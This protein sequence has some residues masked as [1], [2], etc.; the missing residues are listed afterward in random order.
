MMAEPV[1]LKMKNISKTFPGVKALDDVHIDIKRGEVHALMG[2]N[3]AGKSTLI[4]IISGVQKPDP[5]G[6]IWV[7]GNQVSF[8]NA[9]DSIDLGINAIYQ[10]LS[11]F[12]NL[13]VAENIYLGHSTRLVNWKECHEV[14]KDVLGRMGMDID[15]HDQLGK[16]SIAKQ[17]IVAIARAISMNSKLLIMDEPTASLSFNEISALF[18]IIE[19]LKKSNMAI[20]FISHKLDEVFQVADRISVLRDGKWIGCEAADKLSEADL[21]NMMVG[22]TVDKA[23]LN[24]VSY[25]EDVILKVDNI[26]KA[27]NYKDI[28]FT[29]KRGEIL[30]ITGLVGTGRTEVVKTLYGMNTQDS[31]TVEFHGKRVELKNVAQAL[32]QKVA[33]IPEDRHKEALVVD[34]DL[35]ENITMS[36][37]DSMLKKSGLIDEKK[38][39]DVSDEY[40]NLLNIKPPQKEKLVKDLSGG[41]QQKTAIAK[42]MAGNPDILILD[43]PTHGV[44][45]ASKAEIHMLLKKLAQKGIG[46]IIV[47]SEWQEVFSLSDSVIIM[48]GGRIIHKGE[49]KGADHE[50]LMKKAILGV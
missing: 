14:A 30:A 7:E 46:I 36:V 37:L 17:Q 8:S 3:G 5:G 45:V 10:D 12:P 42:G 21:V 15:T 13:T 41:N 16:L 28:S 34:M 25:A 40:I 19:N 49:T 11:L 4:K 9:K 43:E 23:Y 47:S 31:G 26:S 6:E 44:D 50:L 2:E 35:K 27:G 29:L 24:E 32:E 38:R 18:S 22:R 20:L 39:G 48:H 1:F 33:Y